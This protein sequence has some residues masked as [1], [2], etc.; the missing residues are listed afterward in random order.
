MP[1]LDI[2]FESW[3]QG[4]G[5]K[6]VDPSNWMSKFGKDMDW[7]RKE[8]QKLMDNTINVGDIG[9]LKKGAH[10]YDKNGK[11]LKR[12]F[13]AWVYDTDIIVGEIANGCAH[14]STDLTLKAYTGW[15][16]LENIIVGEPKPEPEPEPEPKPEPEPE[17]D[18]TTHLTKIAKLFDEISKEFKEWA[19]G[20]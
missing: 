6:H 7:F 2:H 9:R 13:S 15:T 5:N 10:V 3:E 18:A 12:E 11:D 17:P 4:Y 8:V 14:F 16:A 20:K 1:N 19:D